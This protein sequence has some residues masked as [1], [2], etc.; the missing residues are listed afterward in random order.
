MLGPVGPWL[1]MIGF[2][3]F[4][5]LNP[6]MGWLFALSLG[7]Q[8]QRERVIWLSL[9]PIAAGHALAIG[10]AVVLVLLG[11]RVVSLA[12]LQWITAG[13]LL[14]FGLY[15]LFNYYRHPRWVGMKVGA[16]DLFLWSFLMATAHGAGLMVV[17]VLLGV[18]GSMEGHAAHTGHGESGG[19]AMLVAVALHTAAMLLVM[20]I[21]AW[22]VYRKFGLAI[23][24]QRWVNFDLIWAC[25][26]LV[27]A[28]IAALM[29]L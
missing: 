26:L 14:L 17:P 21:T 1:A 5:G 25:A 8:Q 20:G 28:A 3:A 27:A 7:L 18:A 22:F 29:A 23:L 11:L 9:I 10:L 24:R 4:H 16:G 15:K 2:G 19:V 13:V 6:G 12:A